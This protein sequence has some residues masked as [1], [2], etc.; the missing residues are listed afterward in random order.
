MRTILALAACCALTASTVWAT[1][2]T[3][4]MAPGDTLAVHADHGLHAITISEGQTDVTLVAIQPDTIAGV[5]VCT[6]HDAN[7]WHPIVKRNGDGSI[8]CTYGHEH[9]D[10]PHALDALFGPPN[11]WYGG[12]QS[13]SYPWHTPMENEMKHWFYKDLVR[14]D[15]QPLPTIQLAAYADLYLRNIRAT[16]HLEGFSASF[17]GMQMGFPITNHSFSFEA[18]VCKVGGRC[19][20]AQLGGWQYYGQGQV[21]DA[22]GA[23]TCVLNCDPVPGVDPGLRHVHGGPTSGRRDFT[24]YGSNGGSAPVPGTARI[25]VNLGTV[26]EATGY[27]DPADYTVLHQYPP[28]GSTFY[29]GSWES[30]EVTSISIPAALDPDRDGY[31]TWSGYVTRYGVMQSDG[32]CTGPTSQDCVP[33]KLVDVPTGTVAYRDSSH[34]AAYGTRFGAPQEHDVIVTTPSGP[35]SLLR[36]PN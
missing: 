16:G 30:L 36:F 31:V 21:N 22:A 20:T 6:D 3:I 23:A 27:V 34:N 11:S 4:T 15:L 28:K 12:S 25:G 10:D 32:A 7:T 35:A 9:G 13:I 2:Q 5:P 24:W 8:A 29:N 26:G 14:T 19:G 18:E 1:A 33:V 17:N